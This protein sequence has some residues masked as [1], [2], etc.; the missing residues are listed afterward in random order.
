MKNFTILIYKQILQKFKKENYS[1]FTLEQYCSNKILPEHFI[2]LRHDI[3]RKPKNALKIAKLENELCI[4]SSYYFRIGKESNQPE[5]IKQIAELG[6]EIGYHY[7]DLAIAKGD[8]NKAIKQ[9]ENNLNYF[10]KFYPVKTMCMHGSPLS[11]WDNRDLWEKYD[12]RKYGII[13]EPYFDLDFNKVFYVT[14]AGRSWNNEKVSIRDKVE[15]KFNISIHSTDDIIKL[16]QS[17]NGFRQ[18]MIST[19]PHNWAKTEME[20]WKIYLWQSIKNI[21][22]RAIIKIKKNSSKVA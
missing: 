7:E 14:E 6:H 5:I 8:Y 4:K 3:D 9:F 16:L 17:K 15:S 19:H 10:R 13:C 21:V 12:Y 22:K 1:F 11:K 20:W 2:I 18:I